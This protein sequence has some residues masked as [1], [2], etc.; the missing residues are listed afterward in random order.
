MHDPQALLRAGEDTIRRLARRRFDID[1]DLLAELVR[2]RKDV[3]AELDKLRGETNRAARAGGPDHGTDR[4]RA[5]LLKERVRELEIGHKA[6]EQALTDF[7]LAVPNLP[8]DQVPDGVSDADAV[9]VRRV[10]DPV[11]PDFPVCHHADFGDRTGLIDSRRAAK[12]SGAR[13]SVTRGPVAAL[14]RALAAFFLDLH[15]REHGYLEH[16]VPSLVT[17]ETMTGTGQLPKFADDLFAT[18]VGDRELFLIPT[19]EVPLVNLY[20]GET[21]P[22]AALPIAVT[23]HTSCFRSEAGSYGR[24]T[25]GII[26]L[27]EFGKVELVRICRAED[28]STELSRIVG[29]AEECLRRLELAYRVVT[30]AAGDLGFSATVT[31]DIEVWLPSQRQYREIS[32]CS[33]CGTFQARHARIRTREPGGKTT[34][35]ATLNGSGLPIGR[36]LVAVLEQHQQADGGVRIPEVLVPYTGFRRITPDGRAEE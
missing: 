21:I 30:L 26:R 23:A 2:R 22:P 18:S 11:V 1:I 14:Q 4:D 35:A 3:G 6:A 28:S 32:S 5:R 9:E 29:H 17:R 12:L 34:F 20:A 31:H 24:D 27:H 33:D 15:T 8:A 36:T 19:A 10:G 16:T 25:R 7:L 13:F